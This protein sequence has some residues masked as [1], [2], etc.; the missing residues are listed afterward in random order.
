MRR[1]GRMRQEG[2][3]RRYEVTFCYTW[4]AGHKTE[5]GGGT[6]GMWM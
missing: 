1:M 5:L 3:K 6:Y 4:R 2:G